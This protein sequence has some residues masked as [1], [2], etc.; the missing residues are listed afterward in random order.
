MAF[1][2]QRPGQHIIFRRAQGRAFT[3]HE[4]GGEAKGADHYTTRNDDIHD[5]SP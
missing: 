3:G 1:Q 4:P 5:R 2:P